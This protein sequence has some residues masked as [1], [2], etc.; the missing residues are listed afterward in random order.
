MPPGLALGW[1]LNGPLKPEHQ[2]EEFALSNLARAD[3]SVDV[4]GEQ[5]WKIKTSETLGTVCLSFQSM[6]REL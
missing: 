6:T 1:S 4:Q 5:F 2:I 3:E